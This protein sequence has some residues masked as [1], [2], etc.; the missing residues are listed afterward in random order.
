MRITEK[1]NVS[2]VVLN[3]AIQA[4]GKATYHA[5]QR[6]FPKTFDQSKE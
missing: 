3:L 5:Q 1:E 4:V 2:L 6:W